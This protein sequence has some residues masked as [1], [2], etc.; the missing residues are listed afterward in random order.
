MMTD[1]KPSDSD[2]AAQRRKISLKGSFKAVV[3]N[4]DW[5]QRIESGSAF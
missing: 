1:G 4:P 5:V 3:L 2:P